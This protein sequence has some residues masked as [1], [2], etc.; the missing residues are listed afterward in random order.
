LK[1]SKKIFHGFDRRCISYG[2][3]IA[4]YKLNETSNEWIEGLEYRNTNFSNYQ[5][6]L[7][8]ENLYHGSSGGV[9]L[10]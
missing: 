3:V 4:P 10:K 8:N 5:C 2:R 1:N 9:T 7:S 6:I